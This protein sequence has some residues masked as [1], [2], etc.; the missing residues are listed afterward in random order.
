LPHH[1]PGFADTHEFKLLIV[2]AAQELAIK[3]ELS[4]QRRLF[5]RVAKRVD[6]PFKMIEKMKKKMIKK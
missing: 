5:S 4:E 3:A 2:Y 6:L 1:F